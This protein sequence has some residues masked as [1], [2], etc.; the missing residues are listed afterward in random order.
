MAGCEVPTRAASSA[1]VKPAVRRA[2]RSNT[3]TSVIASRYLIRYGKRSRPVRGSAVGGVAA[4]GGDQGQDGAG[5][6]DAEGESGDGAR[7][8]QLGGEQD[9]GAERNG[10]EPDQ[11]EDGEP[12]AE[13]R[14]VVAHQP[15]RFRRPVRQLDQQEQAGGEQRRAGVD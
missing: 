11:G 5:G 14:A 13:H 12:E 7:Q 10:G 4:E 3:A 15:V 2:S 1:W 9:Q 6:G 8:G